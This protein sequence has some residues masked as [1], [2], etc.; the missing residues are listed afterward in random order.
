M[1][2][3][4]YYDIHCIDGHYTIVRSG[5]PA[6]TSIQWGDIDCRSLKD[7]LEH[8]EYLD[9]VKKGGYAYFRGNGGR[10]ADC[11][12]PDDLSPN[13]AAG[14]AEGWAMKHAEEQAKHA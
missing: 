11:S 7:V 5:S 2:S 3:Y 6:P 1:I 10:R 4:K 9:S 12:V 8:I 14:F 13:Q